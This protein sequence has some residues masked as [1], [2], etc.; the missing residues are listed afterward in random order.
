[1][2]KILIICGDCEQAR[3]VKFEIS[4]D[5][6]KM[7]VIENNDRCKR[8]FHLPKNITKDEAIHIISQYYNENGFDEYEKQ[9]KLCIAGQINGKNYELQSDE[10]SYI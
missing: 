1:M 6:S 7:L 10:I 2:E 9:G 4:K 3:E 8:V 5:A